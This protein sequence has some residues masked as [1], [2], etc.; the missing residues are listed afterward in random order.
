MSRTNWKRLNHDHSS[1]MYRIH[2]RKLFEYLLGAFLGDGSVHKN[3]KGL[4]DSISFAVGMDSRRYAENLVSM[5][6]KVFKYKATIRK[7]SS[8]YRVSINSVYI[9]RMLFHPWK[10]NSIWQ[11][12]Q[13][14]HAEY[15]LGGIV[16][17]DGYFHKNQL[18]ISQK[19]GRGL[20]QLVTIFQCLHIR[21]C[22]LS[23]RWKLTGGRFSNG[24]MLRI[25]RGGYTDALYLCNPKRLQQKKL[26]MCV[27]GRAY[28][29]QILNRLLKRRRVSRNVVEK[30]FSLTRSQWDWYR[31]KLKEAGFHKVSARLGGVYVA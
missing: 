4:A 6:Y 2:D 22:V 29:G 20:P 18:L 1:I 3:Q 26:F 11:L 5:I 27:V 21:A 23:V 12:K 9:A 14:K 17:T 8:V 10:V 24:E 31:T 28:N 15:F 30:E 13:V 19:A 16:D 7:Y 25:Q